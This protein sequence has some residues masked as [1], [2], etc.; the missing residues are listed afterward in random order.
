MGMTVGAGLPEP[1][2][3]L[4]ATRLDRPPRPMVGAGRMWVGPD[5]AY[6]WQSAPEGREQH[7]HD[8][9]LRAEKTVEHSIARSNLSQ[10]SGV[11]CIAAFLTGRGS[12]E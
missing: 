10:Y 8:P 1:R 7:A 11:T 12:I 5:V 4:P 9:T 6:R 2:Q 3:R